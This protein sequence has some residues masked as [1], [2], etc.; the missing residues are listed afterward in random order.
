MVKFRFK[1]LPFN[2]P[3]HICQGTMYLSFLCET[4]LLFPH[5]G[6]QDKY[7]ENDDVAQLLQHWEETWNDTDLLM[8]TTDFEVEIKWSRRQRWPI[9]IYTARVFLHFI[10]HGWLIFLHGWM[11][12]GWIFSWN[13]LYIFIPKY[14]LQGR[15]KA[16]GLSSY[17]YIYYPYVYYSIYEL[18]F[19]CGS[20]PLM[21][22][23][24]IVWQNTDFSNLHFQFA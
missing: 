4:S 12:V 7:V 1:S 2:L 9:L 20:C 21:I 14:L 11:S 17:P 15:R 22:I 3:C 16:S 8:F 10:K 24:N 6:C 23:R 18:L 13:P 19:K 5:G